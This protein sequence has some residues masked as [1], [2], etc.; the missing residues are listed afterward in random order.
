MLPPCYENLLL[1]IKRANYVAYLVHH[2]N[3]LKPQLESYLQHAWDETAAATWVETAAAT[4]VETYSS[5][6]QI[7]DILIDSEENDDEFEALYESEVDEELSRNE[8]E[9]ED[10]DDDV[11]VE[12]FA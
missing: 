10:D 3:E 1:H 7:A 6:Q 2:A 11:D 9:D 4:W 5:L 12:D 8:E